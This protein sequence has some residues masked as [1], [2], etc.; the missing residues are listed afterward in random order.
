MSKKI[1]TEEVDR[2]IEA[3]LCL[4]DSEECYSL[5][6]DICTVNEH[7]SMAQ[8]IEEARMLRNLNTYLVI[9]E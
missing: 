6:E 2:L 9:A 1:R 5:F 7:L 3:I 8:R 4:E